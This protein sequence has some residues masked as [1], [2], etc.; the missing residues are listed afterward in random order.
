MSISIGGCDGSRLGDIRDI[1]VHGVTGCGVYGLYMILK[2]SAGNLRAE[3]FL[4]QLQC[5][6]ELASTTLSL[7]N[8]FIE[9]N[10]VVRWTQHS[11][12]EQIGFHFYLSASQIAAI[13][14]HRCSG[15]IR[16]GVWLSGE[17]V[18]EGKTQSFSDKSEYVIPK[19]QWIEA[20]NAMNY[21]DSL[22]FELPMPKSD[23]SV[24]EGVR[25]L[26]ERA[27]AHICNGNYQ[28]CVGLC[29]QIIEYVE[30]QHEDKQAAAEAIK[31]Y[32]DNR[33]DMTALQRMLFLR[34]SLKNLLHLGSHHGDEFSRLQA[35]AIL[36]MTL[37]LLSS[38]EVGILK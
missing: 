31:K 38:P 28:E 20:L 4:S 8:G 16:L 29:R 9:G 32:R 25:Q 17:A 5:R 2:A 19:Q 27:Q 15:D 35:Q 14:S 30:I 7:A 11:E 18:Y 22:L 6:I 26:F 1:S 36:G 34:E 3:A 10:P 21:Q 23:N 24:E 12:V 37:S 33:Q 13:E